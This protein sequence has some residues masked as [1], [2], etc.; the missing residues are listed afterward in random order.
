M[1]ISACHFVSYDYSS[2][3]VG[4]TEAEVLSNLPEALHIALELRLD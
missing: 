2:L 1:I 3:V 4:E